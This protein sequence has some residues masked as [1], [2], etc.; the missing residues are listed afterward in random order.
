[1]V[2]GTAYI[3]YHLTKVVTAIIQTYDDYDGN[4]NTDDDDRAGFMMVVL[5][6]MITVL[7]M[8]VLVWG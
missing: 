1:M 4:I 6:M 2:M 7:I 5:L 8:A 3:I